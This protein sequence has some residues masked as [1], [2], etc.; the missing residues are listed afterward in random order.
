MSIFTCG[1]ARRHRGN[2]N[3]T[4]ESSCYILQD[5]IS[6]DQR[7]FVPQEQAQPKIITDQA[8]QKYFR[9]LSN[10]ILGNIGAAWIVVG[11][12]TYAVVDRDVAHGLV[13]GTGAA[14]GTALFHVWAI[15]H[16]RLPK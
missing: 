5:I 10:R 3:L 13:N 2:L 12:L 8:E 15:R 16:S 11:A 1:P 7:P 6:P 14:L 4:K 9:N